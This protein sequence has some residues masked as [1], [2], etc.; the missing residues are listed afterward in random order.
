VKSL[1]D[2]FDRI[3]RCA[4]MVKVSI[5]VPC[6]NEGKTLERVVKAVRQSPVR[7]IEVIVVD[8][9]SDDGTSTILEKVSSSVD[10]VICQPRNLGKGAALRAGFA[11]V[12]GSVIVIQDADLEY[13]PSEYPRLLAP[14]LADKADV[15]L[16]TRFAGGQLRKFRY[17]WQGAV[18]RFATF[19]SNA[20]T[21]LNLTDIQTG[22]KAFRASL[23]PSVTIAENRFGVDAE[24][25]AK[26][27][28]LRCR[29]K[30]V[31]INYNARTYAEGKKVG[32]KDGLR[33]LYVILKY[34]MFD[35]MP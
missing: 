7:H 1:A 25:I 9:C 14:I 21:G 3:Q 31:G 29:I 33:A 17:F 16:G 5:V 28:R 4:Q 12:T 34:G 24:L 11:A 35:R 27:A 18:N 8:D 19:L 26:F 23:L 20:F 6:F 30:E 15:V 32:W 13:D 2:I 10:R 22:H